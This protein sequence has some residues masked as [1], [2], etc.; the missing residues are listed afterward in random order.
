MLCIKYLI[1]LV[2]DKFSNCFRVYV[3]SV[4]RNR[5]AVYFIGYRNWVGKCSLRLFF[6]SHFNL[7]QNEDKPSCFFKVTRHLW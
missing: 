3:I 5:I 7:G 4:E 1:S 2:H 6:K